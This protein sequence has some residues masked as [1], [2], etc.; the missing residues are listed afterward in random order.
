[1]EARVAK[2]EES[3][4]GI[5][6]ALREIVPTIKD[7]AVEIPKIRRDLEELPKIRV[8]L[9]ELKGRMTGVE[10]QLRQVPSLWSMGGTMLAINAGIVAVAAL[11]ITLAKRLP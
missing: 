3:I 2:L 1:M 9:A 8:D 4:Q 7:I 6:K 11:I 10:G 5:D